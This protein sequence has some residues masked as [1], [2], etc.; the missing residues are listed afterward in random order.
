MA[1][2]N[3]AL[4]PRS[5]SKHTHKTH[6][7]ATVDS[8]GDTRAIQWP[9]RCA[10]PAVRAETRRQTAKREPEQSR[11]TSQ[12]RQTPRMPQSTYSRYHPGLWPMGECKETRRRACKM[13]DRV[14]GSGGR[15]TNGDTIP[16]STRKRERGE[17]LSTGIH[18]VIRSTAST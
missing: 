11:Y 6:A 16:P 10:M 1:C 15:L 12:L 8:G 18:G 2:L 13:M 17:E 14:A 4:H 5:I 3:S 9:W 7:L